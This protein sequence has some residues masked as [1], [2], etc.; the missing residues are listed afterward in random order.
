M[1]AALH[2]KVQTLKKYQYSFHVTG[3]EECVLCVQ[4][5]GMNSQGLT[6]F[7]LHL[8]I[9]APHYTKWSKNSQNRTAHKKIVI[10]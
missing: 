7:L 2:Q 1:R 6:S 8:Q 4:F 9:V 5:V 10:I 3:L